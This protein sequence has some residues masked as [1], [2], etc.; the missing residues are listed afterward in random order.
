MS[1]IGFGLL[2]SFALCNFSICPFVCV[3]CEREEHEVPRLAL[4]DARVSQIVVSDGSLYW[5][6]LISQLILALLSPEV[7]GPLLSHL[8]SIHSFD[9]FS[10][11][12]LSF[13]VAGQVAIHNPACTSLV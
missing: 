3:A 11:S 1:S 12:S 7:F 4:V 6:S 10:F 9:R 13:C 5:Q 2:R 8:V